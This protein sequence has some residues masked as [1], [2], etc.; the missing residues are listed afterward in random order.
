MNKFIS[1]LEDIDLIV[2]DR[3]NPIANMQIQSKYENAEYEA[4]IESLN[5]NTENTKSI[6]IYSF[7][8]SL[9]SE[10]CLNLSELKE[11]PKIINDYFSFLNL[12]F[13][14]LS[15]K[16]VNQKKELSEKGINKF[17]ALIENNFSEMKNNLDLPLSSIEKIIELVQG[18]IG[19]CKKHDLNCDTDLEQQLNNTLKKIKTALLAEEQDDSE[20]E[21]ESVNKDFSTKKLNKKKSSSN[22]HIEHS[23]KW[24]TLVEKIE[25]LKALVDSERIFET[26]IV[27]DDV[28][29]L[30]AN[31]DPKEYF[32]EIFFPLYQ[33]ISP[34][35]GDIHK[36]IDLYSSSIQWSIA[37]KMYNIDY[38]KFLDTLERMP[39]NNFLN[40]RS[41]IAKEHFY[42][43][44]SEIKTQHRED[45]K[46]ISN[47]D[48]N[49][50]DIK[51]N[52]RD[53]TS[54]NLVENQE[55]SSSPQ[56]ETYDDLNKLFDF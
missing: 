16:D 14:K 11:I 43:T 33:K 22:S 4:F 51:I 32:P 44:S 28:Q 21:I 38:N 26:S 29:N 40:S 45:N 39:E 10:I 55:P 1:I 19:F 54:N 18:I 9:N 53:S 47:Q 37:N 12:H 52:H 41:N 48:A 6:D 25:V 3:V 27:Y 50:E 17:L 2:L 13:E 35:I 15:P 31:F 23:D 7:F 49:K 8:L 42:Q 30:L 20:E 46:I 24:T 34:I 36:N 5:D 56:E